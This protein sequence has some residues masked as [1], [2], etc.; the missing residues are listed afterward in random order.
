MSG[1]IIT[2]DKQQ[3][4]PTNL[5]F[6]IIILLIVAA[7]YFYEFMLQVS[8]GVMTHDLMKDFGV[9]AAGLGMISGFYYYAYTPMQIPAGLLYDRFGPRV[10]LSISATVCALGALGFGLAPNAYLAGIGRFFMGMGSAF[11]FIGCLV[12]ISRWFPSKYFAFLSGVIMIM[13]SLGAL[14]GEMPLAADVER[15]GW[16]HSMISLGLIGLGIAVL[17]WLIVRDSPAFEKIKQHPKQANEWHRLAQVLRRPQSWWL[18]LYAFCAWSPILI[19]AGLWGVPYIAQLYGIS[20]TKAS[21][22]ISIVWISVGIGSPLFGWVSDKIGRRCLPLTVAAGIS[23]AATLGMLYIPHIPYWLMGV[24]MFGLGFGG[25]GQILS[26]ALVKDNNPPRI[27]GTAIGFNNTMVV[28]GGLLFQP[29]VGLILKFTW[30]GKL[31]DNV[32]VYS[33]SNYQVALAIVPLCALIGTLVSMFMLQESHC[34]ALHGEQ[35]DF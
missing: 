8:P 11:A 22:F 26:F 25:S 17:I 6:P 16:R 7:F 19:V 14:V 23:L 15:H 31:L 10:L 24:C 20:T 21:G 9:T 29:L 34:R 32:P 33:Q 27:V 28:A 3:N 13:S 12:L 4:A 30:E 18:A 2:P 5:F 1:A 35:E